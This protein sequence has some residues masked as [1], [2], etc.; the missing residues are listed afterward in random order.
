MVVVIPFC[1][2]DEQLCLKNLETAIALDG[3]VDFNVVVSHV[4]G[5]DPGPVIK[6]ALQYFG[7]VSDFQ[8]PPCKGSQNFPRPNNWAWQNTVRQMV[9]QNEPWLWWEPDAVP[10][11]AG[12]LKVLADEYRAG[13][14]AFMGNW[15][16][17]N[18]HWKTPY[19]NGLAVYPSN[20][21]EYPTPALRMD[22]P[23]WDVILS[24]FIEARTHKVNHLI[25]HSIEPVSFVNIHQV[26]QMRGKETV[27]FHKC[28]DG[29]LHDLIIQN[30]S[31]LK[32][33]ILLIEGII[34]PN[35]TRNLPIPQTLVEFDL[36]SQCTRKCS[37][38]SPGIPKW[39]RAK[40]RFLDVDLH[41]R[42][43][44][45]LAESLWESKDNWLVYCGHGEP[46]LHPHLVRLLRDARRILPEVSLA[47]YT[48]GDLLTRE[49][50]CAFEA[51]DLDCL[52]WDIYDA[53][54][55]K[56]VPTIIAQ[57]PLDPERVR[58][59]DHISVT[60][61][62]SSRA[63]TVRKAMDIYEKTP[64]RFPEGKLFF[65]F[66][67]YWLLCCEDYA[68]REKWPGRYSPSQLNRHPCFSKTLSELK[69]GNRGKLNICQNCDR[70]GG[71]LTGF[72]HVP[73]LI[74]SKYWPPKIEHNIIFS[75]KRLIIIPTNEKWSKH[76][77]VIVQ[78][79]KKSSLMEGDILI[80]WNDDKIS[81]APTVFNETG[82]IVWEYPKSLGWC[83]ISVGIGQA[84]RWALENRYDWVIKMDTDTAILS[85]GWDT[86]ICR[87]C[88]SNSQLGSIMDVTLNGR[89]ANWKEEFI[90]LGIFHEQLSK[91]RWAKHYTERYLR[92]WDHIQGGL[93]VLGSKALSQIEDSTGLLN[94]D[95]KPLSEV[96]R[97]GEDILMDTKCKISMVPQINSQ[98]LRIYYS[99]P[100]TPPYTIEHIRYYRDHRNIVAIHQVKN[101]EIL[102]T[103]MNEI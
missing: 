55:A 15:V 99:E 90:R 51:V 4:I 64:C 23:S 97:V 81:K 37:F 29:T 20:F 47:V 91:L 66:H 25:Q 100:N 22:N 8:Y 42:V 14:K 40:P 38:C 1:A 16:T 102:K 59:I 93:Y 82:C 95:Q 69:L 62:Y 52:I 43:C 77:E 18:P 70:D 32:R 30:S 19:M 75:G 78:T 94:D 63:G 76:A 49:L 9:R 74:G 13:A 96:E 56:Q 85:K 12:W 27:L 58:I 79:I 67:G 44:K 31:K 86:I 72:D 61:G 17:D 57:S 6:L 41:A 28:K 24:P 54:I 53:K 45:D 11:R 98:Y 3:H 7:K 71:H 83:G 60:C 103:L 46:L 92:R 5:I 21:L 80:L 39:R 35:K 33:T 36:A 73:K 10:L 88:P 50:C 65:T 48:N 34:N 2:K 26:H 84:L 87:E 101:I 68:L 89:H